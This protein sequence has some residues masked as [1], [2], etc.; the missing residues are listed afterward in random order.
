MGWFVMAAVFNAPPGWPTPPP[1]WVPEPGWLP[2]ASWP[3]A[4]AGWQFWLPAGPQQPGMTAVPQAAAQQMQ[5][6]EAPGYY[7]ATTPNGAPFPV[8]G[9]EATQ[10][11]VAVAAEAAPRGDGSRVAA[12]F[13]WGGLGLFALLGLTS[14]LGG[15]L[16]FAGLFAFVVAVIALVRGRVRWA[17]LPGRAMGGVAL[18][19]SIVAMSVGG[20]MAPSAQVAATK[21]TARTTAVA[22]PAAATTSTSSTTTTVASPT[23]TDPV[24]A[25]IDQAEPGTALAVLGT[26]AVKGRAPM[27][28]YTRAMFGAAWTD[29]DRNG[30]DQRND[31]LR[32][33]LRGVLL[34]AGTNGCVVMTGTLN[35]PYTATAITFTRTSLTSSPVEIDHVV[36]LADAWVKGAQSWDQGMRTQFANDTLNLNA[37]AAKANASKGAGDAATWLPPNKSYRC[38]YVARQVA[39]KAR[40][41]LAVTAAERTAIA[42]T[43]AACPT[44]KLPSVRVAK[45]GGYPVY[46]PPVPKPAPA[47]AQVPA[48][49]PAPVSAPVSAP[50]PSPTPSPGPSAPSPR[51]GVHPGAF[52]SPEG[53]LGYTSAGTL[54]RCS[55]KA[56]DI[57]ARWRAA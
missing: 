25:G 53:A 22:T 8:S 49:Q 9:P 29:T 21:P 14:G 45:L 38:A 36:P 6:P 55:F 24:T 34:K 28:G 2:D 32:R 56:G 31:T 26:L 15:V 27:T 47:P 50:K 44:M 30:C 23:T 54:M 4:P 19:G 7:G 11:G 35:D 42:E 52:C 17:H 57:R 20:A 40:Y 48:P 41:K 43:L 51:Q 1:G 12:A 37:V 18:V 5:S 46:Q 13:G 3:P 39:V 16:K 10:A 33:D